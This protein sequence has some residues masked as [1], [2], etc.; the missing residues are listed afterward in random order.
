[1]R[2]FGRSLLLVHRTFIL[3]LV[4]PVIRA[5]LPLRRLYGISTRKYGIV[6]H[7]SSRVTVL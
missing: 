3:Y 2:P 5:I 1:M 7:A 6:I 4:L